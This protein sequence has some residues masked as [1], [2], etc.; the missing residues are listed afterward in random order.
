[1]LEKN[2]TPAILKAMRGDDRF[3]SGLVE[4]KV[5]TRATLPASALKEHQH[6]A[7]F[8]AKHGEVFFKIPDSGFAQNPCDAFLMKR[9][10]AWLVVYFAGKKK[11]EEECWAI[12][13]DK[14]VFGHPITID[15]AR[16]Y[17]VALEL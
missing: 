16:M 8:A 6:H 11:G 1:M 15:Y 7:L 13:V 4:I 2:I 9:S 10:E 12:D 5:C 14:V 3:G 17:G